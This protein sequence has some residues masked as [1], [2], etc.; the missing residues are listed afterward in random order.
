MTN[1]AAVETVEQRPVEL[2]AEQKRARQRGLAQQAIGLAM[3]SR[4]EDSLTV[5]RRILELFPNDP[6]ASNRI[7]NALSELNRVPEA[8]EAYERTLASQP[9]NPIALRNLQRLQRVVEAGDVGA[10]ASQK[11]SPAFFVEEVG[12]TGLTALAELAGP[13]SISRVA[14]GDEVNLKLTKGVLQAVLP[15]ATYLG[16]V[17]HNL[18]ERLTRLMKSGNKYQ[19]G[20]VMAEPG[21][22]R[23]MVRETVQSPEN[24]GRI[25]FPPKTAAV[26]A[27]TRET[28]LRRGA[29]DEEELDGDAS[30]ADSEDID[31]DENP[32]EFGFSETSLAGEGDVA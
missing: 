10:K 20:V 13:E 19:A 2:S 15:D 29:D 7:G 8:L 21:R 30:D 22:V 14:A 31:D 17:E 1:E 3:Q 4:W 25:S 24:E 12:K 11:L 27:Y 9:T 6:E 5:N 28:L 23:L 18:A 26:R 16:N 32:A